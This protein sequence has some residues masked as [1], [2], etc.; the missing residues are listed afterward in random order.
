MKIST[1]GALVRAGLALFS[2]FSAT[3]A[4]RPLYRQ[5]F[6]SAVVKRAVELVPGRS[7]AEIAGREGSLPA[8]FRAAGRASNSVARPDF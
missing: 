5:K 2:L 1:T 7:C 8:H 6:P 3:P 4:A